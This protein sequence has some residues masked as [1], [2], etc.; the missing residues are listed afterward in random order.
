MQGARQY[1]PLLIGAVTGAL[2]P[3][4]TW[5]SIQGAWERTGSESL[6]RNYTYSPEKTYNRFDKVAAIVTLLVGLFLVLLPIAFVLLGERFQ[7]E[8]LATLI[9]GL[10]VSAFSISA[11]LMMRKAYPKW[12]RIVMLVLFALASLF[13]LALLVSLISSLM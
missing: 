7:T 11:L 5:F 1:I 8:M 4:I 10:F 3:V 6:A 13:A 2:N 12:M 9:P